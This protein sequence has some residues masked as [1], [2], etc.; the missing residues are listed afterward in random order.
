[1]ALEARHRIWQRR[2]WVSPAESAWK[3]DVDVAAA[4]LIVTLG[5]RPPMPYVWLPAPRG[6]AFCFARGYRRSD[7]CVGRKN[8]GSA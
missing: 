6:A 4:F 2:E 7:H 3:F 5:K 1:M 8:G